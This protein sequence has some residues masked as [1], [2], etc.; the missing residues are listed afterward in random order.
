MKYRIALDKEAPKML[1]L[2][3]LQG[4]AQLLGGL[5]VGGSPGVMTQPNGFGNAKRGTWTEDPEALGCHHWPHVGTAEGRGDKQY[6]R[7]DT[8]ATRRWPIRIRDCRDGRQGN[9]LRHSCLGKTEVYTA[10][11]AA[12]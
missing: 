3:V 2:V 6:E 12:K 10:G 8:P 4:V 5:R 7:K 1:V 11:K 9:Q